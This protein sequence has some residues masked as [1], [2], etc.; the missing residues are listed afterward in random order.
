MQMR[1]SAVLRMADAATHVSTYLVHFN[2][3]A[4]LVRHWLLIKRHVLPVRNSRMDLAWGGAVPTLNGGLPVSLFL[5]FNL[6]RQYPIW[7]KTLSMHCAIE[8]HTVARKKV[9]K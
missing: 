2:A 5:S 4:Q 3:A 6:D 1:M 8:R 9:M 7:V